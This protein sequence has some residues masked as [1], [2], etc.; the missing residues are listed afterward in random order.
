MLA[1]DAG[2][3]GDRLVALH[4]SLSTR[5]AGLGSVSVRV[6]VHRGA[7]AALQLYLPIFQHTRIPWPKA[8]KLV[9]SPL[10]SSYLPCISP[11]PRRARVTAYL[12]FPRLPFPAQDFVDIGARRRVCHVRHKRQRRMRLRLRL[13][14][15][16]LVLV[17]F[18]QRELEMVTSRRESTRA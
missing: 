4:F 17:H 5:V 13:R 7:A 1:D 15:W 2:L 16:C 3:A 6:R 10:S 9:A 14:L 18:S 12:V 8:A 11:D